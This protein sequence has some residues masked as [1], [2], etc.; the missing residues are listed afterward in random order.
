[1]L[2][3]QGEAIAA[4]KPGA[5]LSAVMAAVTNRLKSKAPHLEKHLTKNCGFA[6]VRSRAASLARVP[7]RIDRTAAMGGVPPSHPHAVRPRRPLILARSARAVPPR[8][9]APLFDS[10]ARRAAVAPQGIEFKES[11]MQLNSKSEVIVRAGM[12]FNV[13]L[14]LEN[15]EDKEATDKRAKTCARPSTR[16][17]ARTARRRRRRL[18]MCRR[19]RTM[20]RRPCAH[21]LSAIECGD[22]AGEARLACRVA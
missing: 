9:L 6:T 18:Q 17:A 13:A 1:M 5:K 12:V 8:R 11:Q 16:D 19:R 14:G 20:P 15:V 3:L 2:E 7:C 22:G 4:L 10:R 21:A